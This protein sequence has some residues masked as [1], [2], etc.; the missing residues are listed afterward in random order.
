MDA[1]TLL[2]DDHKLFKR[3]LKEGDD[4]TERAAKGRKDLLR[5]LTTAL[6]AH[7]EIEE[8]ILY[9]ALKKHDK[10]KEIVLEG[11]QEHHVADLIVAELHRTAVTDETWGA[12]WSVLKENI[13]HHI[14][15]EEEDMFKKARQ[16][17]DRAELIALGERMAQLRRQVRKA[18]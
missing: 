2:K 6:K 5:R 16:I 10:A 12:R 17:F 13:E 8:K 11:Y 9:P 7:E 14:E 15:E 3:L 4:T 18:A 1:V